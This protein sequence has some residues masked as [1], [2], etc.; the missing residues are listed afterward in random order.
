MPPGLRR[1]ENDSFDYRVRDLRR[2]FSDGDDLRS[3]QKG[4][5]DP[6]ILMNQ[7]KEKNKRKQTERDIEA[8]NLKTQAEAQKLESESVTAT[9]IPEVGKNEE[10]SFE[11]KVKKI[12]QAGGSIVAAYRD[13][14][15]TGMDRGDLPHIMSEMRRAFPFDAEIFAA[16][17]REKLYKEEVKPVEWEGKYKNDP[18]FNALK[19]VV[20]REIWQKK[21]SEWS[22]MDE[23]SRD[24]SLMIYCAL[25]Q[26]KGSGEVTPESLRLLD[27]HQNKLEELGLM[28]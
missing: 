7:K 11:D 25:M 9:D 22:Q 13:Y 4:E 12:E 16:E 5:V 18:M 27:R 17:W 28:L 20:D 21:V 6:E 10:I 8:L 1:D 26:I 2:H 24:N 14:V 15:K 23:I 3:D 19:Q